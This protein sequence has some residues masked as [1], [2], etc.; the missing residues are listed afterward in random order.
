MLGASNFQQQDIISHLQTNPENSTVALK[1]LQK[2]HLIMNFLNIP[3]LSVHSS[4]FYNR[5]TIQKFLFKHDTGGS[6][7][8]H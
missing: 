6:L 1:K 5:I 3:M 4:L 7:S 8:V 2:L